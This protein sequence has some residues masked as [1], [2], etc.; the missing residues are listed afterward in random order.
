MASDKCKIIN[1]KDIDL[2][3][4]IFEFNITSSIKLNMFSY[5]YEQMKEK[6]E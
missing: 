4:K 1:I 3:L 6:L 2:N 5:G